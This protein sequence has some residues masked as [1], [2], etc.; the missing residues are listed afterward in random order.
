MVMGIFL[1]Q[2]IILLLIIPLLFFG[3]KAYKK[4]TEKMLILSRIVVLVL[5]V[6]ALASPFTIIPHTVTDSEP[7]VIIVSDD[8]VSMD[9]FDN[10]AAS[11]VYD[12]I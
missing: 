9:M 8:T 2:P 5:L 3:Y 7:N 1:E 6:V 12:S 11:R 10:G 4:Y